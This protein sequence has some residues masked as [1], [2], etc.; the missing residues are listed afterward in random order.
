MYARFVTKV[1]FDMGLVGF[2]EPFTNLFTPGMVTRDGRK[3]SKSKGNGGELGNI[4]DGYGADTLRL[5]VLFAGAPEK[6]LEWSNKGVE[7]MHRFL[8]RL[9]RMT[10]SLPGNSG[11]SAREDTPLR[12]RMHRTI[13]KVTED[14]ER[15]HFNTAIS[16]TIELLNAAYVQGNTGADVVD[17]VEMIILLLSPFA[18]HITEE[19]WHRRGHSDSVHCQP[20]PKFDAEMAEEEE[21]T[22]VIQINGRLRDR[23]IVPAG[24]SEEKTKEAALGSESAMRWLQNE[25]ISRV[26]IVPDKL[27]NIVTSSSKGSA[28][29]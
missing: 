19:L 14:I 7:G 26:I 23:I 1:L 3:M 13:R 6:D 8:R 29:N 21:V 4:L 20:W 17:A 22:V 27:V 5:F 15:I 11:D 2:D 9:W 16:A 28:G 18:P 24:M 12:R 10:I 25:E